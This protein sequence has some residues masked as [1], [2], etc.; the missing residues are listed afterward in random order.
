MSLG[1]RLIE[2]RP[3]DVYAGNITHNL[4]P[5]ARAVGLY[6]V[7]WRPD[8]LGITEAGELVGPLEAGLKELKG[9]PA[10]YSQLDSP[11]GWGTHDN[12]VCFVE[13]YLS[14]CIANP[15]ARVKVS[16]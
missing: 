10:K 8:E 16:R 4:S 12:L 15:N 7:L 3:V 2:D 6:E 5:M 1:V 13:N 9:S 14:A 11:N